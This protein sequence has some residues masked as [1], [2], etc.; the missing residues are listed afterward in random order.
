MIIFSIRI[1]VKTKKRKAVIDNIHLFGAPI[2]LEPGCISY[3]TSQGTKDLNE[4]TLTGEWKTREDLDRH[5]KSEDFRKIMTLLDMSTSPPEIKLSEV[6]EQ[7][8]ME[9]IKTARGHVDSEFN[10]DSH[11]A[12]KIVERIFTIQNYERRHKW[13]EEISR[14]WCIEAVTVS[15]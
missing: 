7:Q 5:L 10:F 1:V 3:R 6:S 4:I 11:A 13:P 2:S 8:G 9:V 15:I 12:V 14:L